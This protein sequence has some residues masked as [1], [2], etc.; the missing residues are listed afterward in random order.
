MTDQTKTRWDLY[1]AYVQTWKHAEVKAWRESRHY[2]AIPKPSKHPLY[3]V[4]WETL[5]AIADPK[6]AH[7][8]DLQGLQVVERWTAGPQALLRFIEDL[9]P[10]TVPPLSILVPV[11][12]SKPLGP[13]NYKIQSLDPTRTEETVA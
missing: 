13:S 7:Y 5:R 10:Q 12:R 9:S 6:H 1:K 4:R 3:K 8:E 11:D 2:P